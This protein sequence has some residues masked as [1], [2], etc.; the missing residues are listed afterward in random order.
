MKIAVTNHAVD[1][2]R[3]RVPGAAD[4]EDESV[5]DVI[6][7]RIE[8]AFRAGM[9]KDHPTEAQRRIIPFKAGDSMLY[10]SIGPNTTK[11]LADFAVIGVLYEKELGRV[12]M[13]VTLETV[14]P[15][16]RKMTPAAPAPPE[17][18]VRIGIE[19]YDARDDDE[20]QK[21]LRRRNPNPR[22]VLLYELRREG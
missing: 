22:D 12:G 16:L 21:L 9:V 8:A 10:F 15:G 20:L 13:G 17:Y 1:R 2:Y 11:I 18:I 7:D 14:A 19:S 3:E 6:R 5:R 4:L